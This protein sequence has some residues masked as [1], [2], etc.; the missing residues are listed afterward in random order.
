MA[1][2]NDLIYS[3]YCSKFNPLWIIYTKHNTYLGSVDVDC[4]QASF[5]DLNP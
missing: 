5:I 3:S 4:I 2:R 1:L